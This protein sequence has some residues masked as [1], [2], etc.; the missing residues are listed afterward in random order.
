MS[1][2]TYIHIYT[3]RHLSLPARYMTHKSNQTTLDELEPTKS[4]LAAAQRQTRT[5]LPKMVHRTYVKV[6]PHAKGRRERRFR[7]F[8][9]IQGGGQTTLASHITR[10]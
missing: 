4:T 3:R 9:L 7:R 6:S 1:G 2:T 5:A 10:W 8:K